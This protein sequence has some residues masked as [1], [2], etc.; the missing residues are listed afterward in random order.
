VFATMPECVPDG[1]AFDAAGNLYVSCYAPNKIFKVAPDRTITT[2]ID[3]WE[4]HTLSNPT[5]IAFGGENFDQLFVAN[6]GRWHIAK[7]DLGVKGLKLVSH[8]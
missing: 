2:V 7:I 8:R 4:A 1:L 5:N 6:I 3:N